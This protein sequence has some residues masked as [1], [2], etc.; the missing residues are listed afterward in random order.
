MLLAHTYNHLR[1]KRKKKRRRLSTSRAVLTSEDSGT[2]D[3]YAG[4]TGRLPPPPLIPL[5]SDLSDNVGPCDQSEDDL[6][7]LFLPAHIAFEN[8]DDDNDDDEDV[9]HYH[10]DA[11]LIQRSCSVADIS[12]A[13]SRCR[14]RDLDSD[15]ECDRRRS[16]LDLFMSKSASHDPLLMNVGDEE[17]VVTVLDETDYEENLRDVTDTSSEVGE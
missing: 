7:D 12:I 11:A 9:E 13:R 15:L 16:N 4:Y 1:Q 10:S 8:D 2:E 17:D 6:D 5:P 14:E 3:L